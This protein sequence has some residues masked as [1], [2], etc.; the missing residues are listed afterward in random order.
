MESK[1]AQVTP[2][3]RVALVIGN[4]NYASVGRLANP[5][6]DARV[7]AAMLRRLGFAEVMEL[8]DLTRETMGRALRDF[9]DHAAGA[10][11]ALVFF[12]G[13]GLFNRANTW[14]GLPYHAEEDTQPAPPDREAFLE[15]ILN[16]LNDE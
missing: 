12:A 6:N 15:L 7:V 16:S 3:R 2:S 14:L 9:G 10:E 13:H 11:W 4:S 5:K 8:Y 1:S